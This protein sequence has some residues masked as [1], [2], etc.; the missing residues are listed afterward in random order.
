VVNQV[1]VC[2]PITIGG[3]LEHGNDVF[4][5][6]PWCV[7]QRAKLGDLSAAYRNRHRLSTLGAPHQIA[8]VL[9]EFP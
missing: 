6:T 2:G 7:L 4:P 1:T 5:G 3:A 8:G 9:A